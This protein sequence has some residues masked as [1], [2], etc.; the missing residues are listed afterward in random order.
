MMCTCAVT[1]GAAWSPLVAWS[2]PGNPVWSGLVVLEPSAEDRS[3]LRP[4]QGSLEGGHEVADRVSTTRGAT[5]SG[6]GCCRSRRSRRPY[7]WPRPAPARGGR[8]GRCGHDERARLRPPGGSWGLLVEQVRSGRRRGRPHDLLLLFGQISAEVPD[9]GRSSQTRP[10]ATS[11]CW[12]TSVTGNLACWLALSRPR[13]A[14]ARRG[15]RVRR[16]GRRFPRR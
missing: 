5:A 8:C 7:A 6:R 10:S 1:G 13:R 9:A 11:M 12:K 4:R 2:A 14:R 3:E 15:R 16:R